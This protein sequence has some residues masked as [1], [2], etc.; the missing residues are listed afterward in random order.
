MS[1]GGRDGNSY[2]QSLLAY[3][4]IEIINT[5]TRIGVAP[6]HHGQLAQTAGPMGP[7]TVG[8]NTTHMRDWVGLYLAI[9]VHRIDT[10]CICRGNAVPV[11][12]LEGK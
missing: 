7:N 10:V 12:V 8:Q 2:W 4:C 3:R 9:N 1:T 6:V 5:Y 11:T